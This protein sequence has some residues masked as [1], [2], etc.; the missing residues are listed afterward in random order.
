MFLNRNFDLLLHWIFRP[1]PALCHIQISTC[2]YIVYV[3]TRLHWISGYLDLSLHC[4]FLFFDLSLYCVL[5]SSARADEP[6]DWL[7]AF[8]VGRGLFT[9]SLPKHGTR[10]STIFMGDSPPWANLALLPPIAV[11]R[12]VFKGGAL[13]A[14]PSGKPVRV[15]PHPTEASPPTCAGA[16]QSC[17]CSLSCS[18]FGR[19]W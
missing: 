5:C 13:W 3:P 19:I 16:S 2:P 7:C 4:V 10:T 15:E 17:S 6:A 11:R 1:V 12:Q 8:S 14:R 9:C 18:I